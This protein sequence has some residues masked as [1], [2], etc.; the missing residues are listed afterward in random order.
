LSSGRDDAKVGLTLRERILTTI[1]SDPV[2]GMS[3]PNG[4][5]FG[6][7]SD[8]VHVQRWK[9][10]LGLVD[11]EVIGVIRD[12]MGRLREPLISFKLF[13]RDMAQLA[14]AKAAPPME[15]PQTQPTGVRRND[16]A[17]FDRAINQLADG[18]AAGTVH[19][20]NSDR[21]PF[22]IIAR[23]NSAEGE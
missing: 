4:K 13:D 7:S 1:G 18:L 15:I 16:R 6:K 11:D 19:L 20:D 17:A 3:G 10:D 8:M 12:V 5:Q 14:A 2:S 21:N 22:A 9:S 23:R